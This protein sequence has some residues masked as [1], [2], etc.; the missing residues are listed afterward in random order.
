MTSSLP[1]RH[2]RVAYRA[3]RAA[4]LCACVFICLHNLLRNMNLHPEKNIGNNIN[5]NNNPGLA[6]L[7]LIIAHRKARACARARTELKIDNFERHT[8]TT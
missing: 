5:I 7:C 2:H 1:V 4:G 3:V 6:L 8:H